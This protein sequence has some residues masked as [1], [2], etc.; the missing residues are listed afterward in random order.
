MKWD[1]VGLDFIIKIDVDKLV[2]FGLDTV[3][4]YANVLCSN[5]IFQ[6]YISRH[7]IGSGSAI[8]S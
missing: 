8:R 2:S 6:P 3:L 4:M 1:F 7:L 5:H